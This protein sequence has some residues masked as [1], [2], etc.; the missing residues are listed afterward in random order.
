MGHYPGLGST[1]MV[2]E[3]SRVTKSASAQDNTSPGKKVE[4]NSRGS[5]KGWSP[6]SEIYA[7]YNQSDFEYDTPG[8]LFIGIHEKQ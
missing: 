6:E 5:F 1:N 8:I 4:L 7:M 3:G 2:I